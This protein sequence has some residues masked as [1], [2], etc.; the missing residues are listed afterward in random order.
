[1]SGVMKTIGA[2]AI[3]SLVV[4]CSVNT[5]DDSED[6][7]GIPSK[8]GGSVSET[9]FTEGSCGGAIGENKECTGKSCSCG[10]GSCCRQICSS[11]LGG[12]CDL[13]C[14]DDSRCEG[15]CAGGG[16][17]RTCAAGAT[18]FF[19]CS[20]GGCTDRCEP[21]SNC[22]LACSGGGC[23]QICEAGAK[24]NVSCSGGFCK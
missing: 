17:K 12:G 19:A 5:I 21:G 7:K 3:A 4:A 9:L 13:T 2:F 10:A 11:G 18:C 15:A 22:T 14:N 24:C 16:C 23:T 8:K 6:G 20:G 1:M